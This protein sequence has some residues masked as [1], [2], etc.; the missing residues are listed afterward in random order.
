MPI[1]VKGHQ[2]T[3]IIAIYHFIQLH[4]KF[5]SEN[6]KGINYHVEDLGIDGRILEW[7]LEKQ[8]ETE[9]V[10]DWTH[11]AH[12]GTSRGHVNMYC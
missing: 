9:G 7:I 4:T 3:V 6:V 8:G 11:L 1:Y 5:W 2:I 12:V 10:V